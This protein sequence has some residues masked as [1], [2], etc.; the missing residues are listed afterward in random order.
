[1]TSKRFI[2]LDKI[3]ELLLDNETIN[4]LLGFYDALTDEE[5]TNLKA[6]KA[7]ADL[8]AEKASREKAE[9]DLK[10]ERAAREKSVFKMRLKNMDFAEI[11]NFTGFSI[12]EIEQILGS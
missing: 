1:V 11:N 3:G 4:Q 6:K 12:A 9:L 10:A 7:E 5:I 2:G 8:R